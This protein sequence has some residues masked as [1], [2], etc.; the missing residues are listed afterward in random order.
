VNCGVCQIGVTTGYILDSIGFELPCVSDCCDDWLQA[1]H[2][3]FGTVV[4]V[5]LV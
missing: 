5:G 1:G 3:K 2:Y 4:S